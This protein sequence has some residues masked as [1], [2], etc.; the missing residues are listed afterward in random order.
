M[1]AVAAAAGPLY[2]EAV[3]D[4]AVRLAL[5]S[6]AGRRPRTAPRWS[7]STEASTRR[8]PVVGPAA[9]PSRRIPGLTGLESPSDDLLRAALERLLR[10]GRSPGDRSRRGDPAPVRLFGVD[11][12]TQD[13]VVV[14]QAPGSSEGVWLPEP[15][16]R[17]TGVVA[18][19]EVQV[20][21]SG[22]PEAPV[23]TTRVA[24]DLR[25]PGRRPHSPEHPPANG[26]GPDLGDEAFPSD[27][28]EPTQRAHL[29]VADLATTAALAKQTGDELLWSA[30]SALTDPTP[31]LAQFHRTADAVSLLRRLLTAA[32][33]WPTTR[34]R[35]V[36]RSSAA[37][38]TSPTDADV[39]SSAAQRGAAVTT[40]VGIALSLALV[41]AATGYSMGRRRREVQLAAGTGRRP[42]SA[43]LLYVAELVPGGARRRSARLA[44]GP[45]MVGRHRRLQH[46][47]PLDA[48]VAGLWCAGRWSPPSSRPRTVAAVPRPGARPDGSRVAPSFACRGS[49][50]LVVVAASATAGLLTRPPGADDPLGPLDLLVPPLVVAAIA[51]M[52]A[53]RSSPPR[54]GRPRLRPPTPAHD[55]D[56]AGASTAAGTRPRA[57]GGDDDRGDRPGDARSSRSRR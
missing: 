55:R 49:L 36:R 6:R 17:S 9:R 51:A 19:D 21:L 8:T 11:D 24:R 3:S 7:G 28:R 1:V 31:R 43:G 39:L 48:H 16:A 20:Q 34:W 47:D 52:G 35:C 53:R 5:A 18:G 57:R 14:S 44:R 56:L 23:A 33:S 30:L 2:A 29:V 45:R 42:F 27:A 13:L 38:R 12:P 40:R 4:A 15:V 32:P 54:R 22:L 25:G 46:A 26:S 10:P 37:W 50:V 41:V